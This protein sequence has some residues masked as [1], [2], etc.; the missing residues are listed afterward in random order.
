MTGP[1]GVS[2]DG[3]DGTGQ[4]RADFGYK[5]R[6]L[7]NKSDYGDGWLLHEPITPGSLGALVLPSFK[8]ACEAFAAFSAAD[9]ALG[10]ENS[11]E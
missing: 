9:A 7:I 10:E 8:A 2:P 6:W 5:G 4:L 11:H 1:V 3:P